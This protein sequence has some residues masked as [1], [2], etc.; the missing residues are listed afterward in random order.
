L[1]PGV[2]D[3]NIETGDM[4]IR[5]VPSRLPASLV[6]SV[7]LHAL[8]FVLAV[9]FVGAL[10][11]PSEVP[12]AD[13]IPVSL[14]SLP[15]GGGGPLGDG[16][17]APP[18]PAPPAPAPPVAAAPVTPPPPAPVV[19][20]V[21]KK[22]PPPAKPAVKPAPRPATPSAVATAPVAAGAGQAASGTVRG[23]TGRGAGGGDGSGGDGSGGAR[24]AYG[25]N[26]RPPYPLAA[27]RL[28]HEGR[29]LLEVVV[30]PDGRAARVSVRESSGHPMLDRSAADTV[31]TRWRFIPARRD[32]V[33]VESTVTVPIRFRIHEG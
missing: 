12:T 14:V 19:K 11:E 16:T 20:P 4:E 5:L 8:A 32:G 10:A 27:R 6:T 9:R 22:A 21:V 28:G 31:R 29:V 23:G 15:G 3:V 24:P 17:P 30:T 18:P 13:V 33:P 26:P 25:S 1:Q 7:A 2:A